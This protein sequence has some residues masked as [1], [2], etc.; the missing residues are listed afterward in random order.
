[1]D[2]GRPLQALY[3]SA[4]S[5]KSSLSKA[6][7]CFPMGIAVKKGRTSSLKRCLSIPKYRGTSLKRINLGSNPILF[8]IISPLSEKNYQ[9]CHFKYFDSTHFFLLIYQAKKM[10]GKKIPR[11]SIKK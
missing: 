8:F 5:S 6:I 9:Y 4:H 2:E 11:K 3:C 10:I 7:P 1:M